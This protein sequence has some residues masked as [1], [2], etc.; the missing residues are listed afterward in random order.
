MTASCI[1]SRLTGGTVLMAAATG[2]GLAACLFTGTT[3]VPAAYA[4]A[5]VWGAAGSVF[6][7]VAVTTLQLV[8][9]RPAHGRVMSISATV[10]SWTETIGVPVG[11]LALA[12]LGVRLG[13]LALAGVAVAAGLT[14]LA[15]VTAT[16]PDHS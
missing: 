6:G 2:Y 8:A 13:A 14:G 3:S 10:Q 16:R 7:A 9:P 4:G 15:I 11:G 5:F 1:R 12:A